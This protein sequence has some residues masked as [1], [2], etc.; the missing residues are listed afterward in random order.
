MTVTR[1]TFIAGCSAVAAAAAIPLSG[2]VPMP[3]PAEAVADMFYTVDEPWAAF[4]RGHVPKDV[5]DR[6]VLR[7]IDTNPDHREN[8]EDWLWEGHWEDDGE[9]QHCVVIAES[10]HGYMKI[11]EPTADHDVAWYFCKQGDVGA[12]PITLAR[13]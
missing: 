2:A 3:A 4:V 9:E 12:V 11:G 10:E 7:M 13:Y 6:A 5:F 1:R 8:G